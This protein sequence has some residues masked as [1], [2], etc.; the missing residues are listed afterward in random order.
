MKKCVVAGLTCVT[1]V[2][3]GLS[4]EARVVNYTGAGS[5]PE[6]LADVAN[7]EA[8]PTSEDVAW[9]DLA[10]TGLRSFTF[11]EDVALGG[12]V[13]SGDFGDRPQKD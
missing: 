9:L 11:G 12:L 2:L 10:A 6:N 1:G 3:W 8:E 4:A 7:W 13:I 5:V